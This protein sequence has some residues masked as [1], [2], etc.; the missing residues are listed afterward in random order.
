MILWSLLPLSAFW[1][2]FLLERR[3]RTARAGAAYAAGDWIMNLSGFF[4]QGV[5]VPLS[6]YWLATQFFPEFWPS[7]RGILPLG[8]MGAFLL[9][10]VG[11]DFLY[12]L[13]H[14]GFHKIPCLWKLHAPHHYS[15]TVNIW[16]TSRNALVTHFLFVYTLINP[17]LGYFCDRPDAFFAGAML[18]AA[19]DL[20]RHSSLNLDIP[21]LKGI[22]VMP[23]DHHRHHD[24]EKHDANYGANFIIWDRLFGTAD[25]NEDYPR[26]YAA[27]GA[28]PVAVQLLSPW[29]ISDA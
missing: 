25:M 17:V 16:A 4:M 29:R 18:T 7:A 10:I 24:G 23:R 15:P 9:N 14:R 8:V 6:G 19:L 12:Y 11:V 26:A 22:V 21:A 5:A 1:L 3:Q 2:L 13:Q 27:P 20:L 28:P